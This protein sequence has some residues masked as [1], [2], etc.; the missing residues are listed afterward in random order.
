MIFFNK[1]N[2]NGSLKK[3]IK[4]LK[5]SFDTFVLSQFESFL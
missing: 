3:E 2:Y 5:E 1:K 4:I